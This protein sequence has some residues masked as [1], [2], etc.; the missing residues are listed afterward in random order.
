ME[1]MTY[2]QIIDLA[3]FP[4]KKQELEDLIALKGIKLTDFAGQ[5]FN[6]VFFGTNQTLGDVVLRFGE[7]P[8]NDFGQIG[9]AGI[10]TSG[11]F[12]PNKHN[13]EVELTKIAVA[14]KVPAP[15]IFETGFMSD[16]T[17]WSIQQKSI[18]KPLENLWGTITEQ[19]KLTSLHEM[20]NNLAKLHSFGK[21][22]D[23]ERVNK[24]WHNK[25]DI[26]SN[27]LLVL[28]LFS[29]EQIIYFKNILDAK[30]DN[31]LTKGPGWISPVHLEYM[32][33]HVFVDEKLHIT[34]VIDWETGEKEGDPICDLVFSALWNTDGGTYEQSGFKLNKPEQFDSF[35]KGYSQIIEVDKK[36]LLNLLPVY[37]AIWYLNIIWVRNL[38]GKNEKTQRRIDKAIN[39]INL[40]ANDN[41]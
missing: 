24:Y 27:N 18:G 30:I 26:I 20:G 17:S 3:D 41:V 23:K 4:F 37:D 33:K 31:T 22:V 6:I 7:K 5:S 15:K 32:H 38:Q 21:K 35:L 9:I 13:K 36:T 25:L 39:I 16:G 1:G 14:A 29:N 10:E 28:G 34:G 19:Q 8:K 40:L 12:D 2:N 11:Y